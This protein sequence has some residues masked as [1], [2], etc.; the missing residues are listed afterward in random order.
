[1]LGAALVLLSGVGGWG[2][3]TERSELKNL[4]LNLEKEQ[5]RE[6]AAAKG[7][8]KA[9][10]ALEG[11]NLSLTLRLQSLSRKHQAALNE[12]A[13]LRLLSAEI[14][15]KI[16]SDSFSHA[17]PPD[18]TVK[19]DDASVA[20]NNSGS[21]VSVSPEVN[22]ATGGPWFV[23]FGTYP[24]VDTA[25]AWSLRLQEKG[26]STVILDVMTAER[27]NLYR[28]RVINLSSIAVA[29]VLASQLER[30]YHLEPLSF[31]QDP[32]SF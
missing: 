32:N 1:M 29:K 27:E 7:R 31:G 9:L 26:H 8:K 2:L 16:V 30:D 28:V 11:E 23:N 12:I 14:T 3:A 10:V 4:I 22:L 6:I 19:N 15:D 18:S 25:R 13:K 17:A 5:S 20:T 21:N 24:R